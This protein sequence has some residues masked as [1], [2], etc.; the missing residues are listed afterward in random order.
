MPEGL[1]AYDVIIQYTLYGEEEDTSSPPEEEKW[2]VDS[3]I[4]AAIV[5]KPHRGMDTRN[6]IIRVSLASQPWGGQFRLWGMVN[7][8]GEIDM[9]KARIIYGL[10]DV[11]CW[12][13][14]AGFGGE[15]NPPELK[16]G[17]TLEFPWDTIEVPVSLV[18]CRTPYMRV[19][20]EFV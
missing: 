7:F 14:R 16:P 12:F 19:M 3:S 15:A 6:K 11:T 18:H 10:E 1:T 9:Q 17:S 4:I 5:A 13:D 8:K 2:E 20:S